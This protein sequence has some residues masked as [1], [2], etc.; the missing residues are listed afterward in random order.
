MGTIAF[1]GDPDTGDQTTNTATARIETQPDSQRGTAE[2]RVVGNEVQMRGVDITGNPQD[3]SYVIV[4]TPTSASQTLSDVRMTV[5]IDGETT[6]AQVRGT[7]ATTWNGQFSES[8]IGNLFMAAE[9]GREVAGFMVVSASDGVGVQGYTLYM[10]GAYPSE[11]WNFT[12]SD[13]EFGLRLRFD[14][15]S[16]SDT[17]TITAGDESDGE[18]YEAWKTAV[19]SRF[20]LTQRNLVSHAGKA[21]A[22]DS[23][24][25][26]GAD[27]RFRVDTAASNRDGA[28]VITNFE[29]GR[30]KVKINVTAIDGDVARNGNRV[31]WQ[32]SG[33]DIIIYA[34]ASADADKILAVIDGFTGT[35][36]V[37]DFE[38]LNGV[39]FAE[40]Q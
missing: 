10:S 12:A 1:T 6:P 15:G 23:F 14:D 4:V 13:Q 7:T 19:V 29:D 38:A 39:T 35:F 26:T 20:D 34:G 36:G 8:F 27:D 40:I 2:V 30:D 16:W 33:D 11:S 9:S 31:S 21:E 28:D 24:M 25:G 22:K 17:I 5:E 3:Q 18:I 37:D 32:T